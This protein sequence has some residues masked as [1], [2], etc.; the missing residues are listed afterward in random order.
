MGPLVSHFGVSWAAFSG[1][2]QQKAR[3]RAVPAAKT[4]DLSGLGA[5]PRAEP[6]PAKY[7][8]ALT[9]LIGVMARVPR[10]VGGFAFGVEH[11]ELAQHVHDRPQVFAAGRRELHQV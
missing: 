5:W 6:Q 3:N 9:P 4:G 1:L 10:L 11:L 8:S 7:R 2:G